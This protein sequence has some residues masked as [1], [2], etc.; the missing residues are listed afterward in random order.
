MRKLFGFLVGICMGASVAA[1]LVFLF[2]PNSGVELRARLTEGYRAT[3]EEARLAAENRREELEAE[4]KL[5]Q[6]RPKNR[7]QL[8]S[9]K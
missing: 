7:P 4:L 1:L 8:P 6:T 3:L 5:L 2:A 9:G